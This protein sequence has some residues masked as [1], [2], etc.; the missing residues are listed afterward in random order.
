MRSALGTFAHRNRM[1]EL[2]RRRAAGHPS[3][4]LIALFAFMFALMPAFAAA[5]TS[6]G[7]ADINTGQY[8]RTFSI[9]SASNG[10]Q[11]QDQ[12]IT[13]GAYASTLSD[14]YFNNGD[15]VQ[16]TLTS[17]VGTGYFSAFEYDDTGSIVRS[18]LN[19]TGNSATFTIGSNNLFRYYNYALS[20]FTYTAGGSANN[21][22]T[23]AHSNSSAFLT[24][25]CTP[26]SAGPTVTA[27]SPTSGPA[28]GG[29]AVTITGT[30]FTGATAVKFGATSATGITVVSATS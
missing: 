24:L 12:D 22:A 20:N 23:A 5:A 27:V 26:A 3:R 28:A 25:T 14:F 18:V 29:T 21:D 11:I 16:F 2:G 4:P 7:C 9:P 1:R 15:V 6:K 19:Q 13:F 30:G 17:R 8:N 10:S